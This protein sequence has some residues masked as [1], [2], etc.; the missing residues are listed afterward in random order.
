MERYFWRPGACELVM[1]WVAVMQFARLTAAVQPVL[2]VLTSH[3]PGY[4]Q[5]NSSLFVRLDV[6]HT[7]IMA[8]DT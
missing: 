1:S 8:P 7:E 5:D 6:Q 3:R 4:G 2:V